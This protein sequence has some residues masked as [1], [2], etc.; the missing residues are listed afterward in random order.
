MIVPSYTDEMILK[1]LK[2]D[3][4]SV[5]RHAKKLGE[6]LLTKMPKGRI[7]VRNDEVES[8]MHLDYRSKNGNVWHLTACCK[9][10]STQWYSVCYAEVENDH[11]T[12]SIYYL[13]AVKSP[14]PYYVEL[15]PHAIRRI[16]ERFYNE[17]AGNVFA[18]MDINMLCNYAV[19]D[20]HETGIFLAA[21]KV[22]RDG[23]FHAFTDGDGNTP[24]VVLNKNS[25]FYA[26]RTPA[27]NF[28]FKTFIVP[29]LKEGT[30]KTEFIH[31]MFSI[32]LMVNRKHTDFADKRVADFYRA[33]WAMH[34]TMHRHLEC[35]TERLIPL[36]P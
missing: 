33:L 23:H 11:G 6:M 32:Y 28:I 9:P 27:G 14:H 20:R 18:E 30:R 35:L 36:Y 12:K 19:F 2:D 25:M 31:M 5:K 26:R 1:E 10:G 4:P 8:S 16:R 24:G 7:G 22:G 13:R 17:E 21:G 3:W 15:I 34:P 29:E